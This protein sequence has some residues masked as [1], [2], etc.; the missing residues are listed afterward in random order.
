MENLEGG[1]VNKKL[2]DPVDAAP[3]IMPEAEDVSDGKHQAKLDFALQGLGENEVVAVP[4]RAA[5]TPHPFQNYPLG[6][7]V[8]VYDHKRRLKPSQI[9]RTHLIVLRVNDTVRDISNESIT[10]EFFSKDKQ[11]RDIQLVDQDGRFRHP[12]VE[13]QVTMSL[14]TFHNR[15]TVHPATKEHQKWIFDRLV[16]VGSRWL[17]CCV[18]PSHSAR[19]QIVYRLNR[20]TKK[21]EVDPRYLLADQDQIDRLALMFRRVHYQQTRHERLAQS[22]DREMAGEKN[23]MGVAGADIGGESGTVEP[24]YGDI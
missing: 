4:A 15:T 22:F 21:P 16:K 24:K 23:A 13:K 8:E 18:I 14:E 20:D 12:Q 11:G 1:S 17:W 7:D 9:S 6:M 19:A 3:E 2:T 5:R 10:H